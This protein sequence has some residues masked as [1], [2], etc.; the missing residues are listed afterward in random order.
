MTD[1]RID[2]RVALQALK[3]GTITIEEYA[4]WRRI[5]PDPYR[6]L[7]DEE[8]VEVVIASCAS[9]APA[10][11]PPLTVVLDGH[12]VPPPPG[13]RPRGRR[14][15]SPRGRGRRPPTDKNENQRED[16]P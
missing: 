2:L 8:R 14:G 15:R 11:C 4:R 16:T 13:H 6:G 1:P 5:E 7:S 12:R 9:G 3:N 10:E